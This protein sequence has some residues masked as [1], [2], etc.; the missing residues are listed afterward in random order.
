MEEWKEIP[1]KAQCF[2]LSGEPEL[3]H[4]IKT[5]FNDLYMAVHEDAYQFSL[6]KVEFGTKED[7]EAKYRV[8]IKQ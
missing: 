4:V 3:I 2:Q 8:K 1:S 6:G 5:G 7:I